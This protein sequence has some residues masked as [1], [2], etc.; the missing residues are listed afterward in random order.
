M[1]KA[2][3]EPLCKQTEKALA[4]VHLFV[5]DYFLIDLDNSRFN[6]EAVSL[7]PA[8]DGDQNVIVGA[9]GRWVR[10]GFPSAYAN[11]FWQKRIPERHQSKKNSP[12]W[13]LAATDYTVIVMEHALDRRRMI[14]L[15]EEAR[16]RY[17]FLLLRF[18]RQGL[19]VEHFARWKAEK[20]VPPT[21]PDFIE[22][23]D[24][25]LMPHQKVPL[26][27]FMGL[28]ASAL[29]MEQGTGKTPIVVN[30]VCLE[31]T[32]KKDMYRVLIV[33]PNQVRYN[34]QNEFQR[35][36]TAPG[37]LTVLRGDSLSRTRRLTEVIR[38]D[39]EALYGVAIISID[40]VEST[41]DALSMIP[42]DLV[43]I[44]ES[45][46]IKN[47]KSDRSKAMLNLRDRADIRR[48][49]ILTGTPSPNSV[50]DLWAQLEF[51]GKG[52]SGFNTFENFRSFHGRFTPPTQGNAPQKILGVENLPLL[53]ERMARLGY[54]CSK[55]DAGIELP[56]KT[57]DLIEVQMTR[58]QNEWYRKLRDEL[59]LEL[60]NID[61]RSITANH[62]L[63]KLL[64]LAQ[65]TA[66]HVKWDT[67]RD[68]ETGEV[69]FEGKTEDIPG[70]N[71]K[72]DAVVDLLEDPSRDPNGKT[73]IWAV[74][75]HDIRAISKRLAET[76]H[77]HVTY[78]G[79]TSEK[80]RADALQRFNNDP[81]CRV[82]VASPATAGTGLN[83]LGYDPHNPSACDTFCDHEIFFSINW[84]AAERS[85]AEDRAHR[86]GTRSTVRITDLVVP[87]TIDEEIR[88]RVTRKQIAQLQVQ[89]VREILKAVLERTPE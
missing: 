5:N 56:P 46:Y 77:D 36:A 52:L 48:R 7:V 25:P 61:D 41:M 24:N 44:D 4:K 79:E 28:E 34:W 75:Q 12:V 2:V 71:P 86:K 54:I 62:V 73:I 64:R 37:R 39:D 17:E 87:G 67:Q 6:V 76:G 88:T 53:Q 45:H 14:F 11:G 47:P 26:F 27:A 42:W 3:L 13:T 43:V 40:S 30:E 89:D 18:I 57:Y 68:E 38:K 81:A 1:Y 31:A 78:Y 19:P 29:L 35:F 49:K 15:T 85:Q 51:L 23:P 59:A 21:P 72:L 60:E 66:G 10:D 80:E 22:H 8:K 58:K 55:D 70:G 32:R 50:M 63:T 84:N 74:F 33:C 9:G 82:F 69:R 16:V 20:I 65:I 83:L